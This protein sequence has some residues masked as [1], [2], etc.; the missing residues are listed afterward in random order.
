MSINYKQLAAEYFSNVL[1]TDQDNFSQSYQQIEQSMKVESGNEFNMNKFV[2][3][4]G[5]L[6]EKIFELL[7]GE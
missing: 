4:I 7:K 6:E 5:I 2:F 1:Y 3:E